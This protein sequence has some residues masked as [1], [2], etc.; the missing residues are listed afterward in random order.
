MKNFLYNTF[1][2]F[3]VRLRP[4]VVSLL[5]FL[6]HV[7]CFAISSPTYKFL[8]RVNMMMQ[9]EF[10]PYCVKEYVCKMSN[11]EKI[12][13][14]FLLNLEGNSKFSNQTEYNGGI[15][16]GGYLLFSYNIAQSPQKMR[17]FTDSVRSYYADQKK[18]PPFLCIDHEGGDVN[19][20]KTLVGNF[21]S[22]EKIA[23]YCTCQKAYELYL[24]QGKIL[25][26]LGIQ[27]NLAPVIE[28]KTLDNSGF[29]ENRSFGNFEQVVDYGTRCVNAYIDS[30][31]MPVLKHF[32][33]N[34]NDDPHFGLPKLN[35]SQKDFEMLIL[36]F[37]K[38]LKTSKYY[39]HPLGII[40][41]H[42][43]VGEV[44]GDIPSC[45]S[46]KIVSGILKKRYGFK[47]LIFSDDIYMS[48]LEKNG[49][50]PE[51]S[52]KLCILAGIDVIMM[53][54]KKFTSIM[55]YLEQEQKQD[56]RLNNRITES[57][58][59]IIANKIKMRLISMKEKRNI[60]SKCFENAGF[61][62]MEFYELKI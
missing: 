1:S 13:Q 19:R 37:E 34:T 58:E 15:A 55:T 21:L 24:E 26:N 52:A 14:L 25:K 7:N 38:I 3:F 31:V 22:Q 43:A 42:V 9:D 60:Y 23:E 29:L 28:E 12:A 10:S 59:K 17:F 40:L 8:V 32:P 5:I 54:T 51:I 41:S 44:Y 39:N 11:K 6:F 16:P 27:V 48:A 33:G 2:C 49:Y 36:P 50:S 20:L 53:S 47:G 35:L 57:C 4:F 30:S 61:P 62:P 56:F 45:F 18:I 46:E